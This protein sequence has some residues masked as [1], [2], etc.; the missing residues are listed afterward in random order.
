M[1][2]GEIVKAF[3][4]KF[5][6]DPFRFDALPGVTQSWTPN[7]L[8]ALYGMMN[9]E[10]NPTQ[11]TMA[12]VLGLERSTISRKQSSLDWNEFE[13]RLEK[14]C[15][16]DDETAL[17]ES[18]NETRMKMVERQLRH[19]HRKKLAKMSYSKHIQDL[20]LRTASARPKVEMPAFK[21]SKP[22]GTPEHVVLVLSD[23]HVG[24]AFTKE[25][26]GGIN[27]YDVETFVR[28]AANL[29]AA[30]VEIACNLHSKMYPIPE[31]HVISLG[32]IVQGSNLGGD[33][34]PAYTAM[35]VVAQTEQASKT[36]SD[37]LS[38]WAGC[39]EKVHFY[40][41]VG[42]HGRAGASKNSD[43]VAANFDNTVYGLIKGHMSN[44]PNVLV[45]FNKSWWKTI[46]IN[47]T[48]FMAVHG[49]A[50]RSLNIHSLRQ[51]EQKLQSMVQA[52]TGKAFDVLLLGHFHNF[53]EVE[54][55]RGSVIVNGSFVGGD[56]YS[57]HRLHML[58][59]PSQVLMGVHPD[60]GITW[61]YKIDM[62]SPR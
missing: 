31:L 23:A 49:D 35:D 47:G 13:K 62:E 1:N 28:R 56:I 51:E 45:N 12:G 4:V 26:T 17:A 38:T 50:V 27:E 54:T 14:L 61:Q 29:R 52:T 37:M 60:R 42:N 34:G 57:L 2:A 43:K 32:D 7:K 30:V 20:M 33:W 44:Q 48:S 40:G 10:T 59:R 55:A 8:V 25:E 36:I 16:Q 18:V 39:F 41:V 53:V 11:D 6:E 19:D 21:K 46:D 22:D 3:H 58:S 24:Q 9:S 15:S 5:V